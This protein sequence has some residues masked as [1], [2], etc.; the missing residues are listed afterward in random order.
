MYR[1]Y[2][3]L[4]LS[5]AICMKSSQRLVRQPKRISQRFS[6]LCIII[7]Y[8]LPFFLKLSVLIRCIHHF[9]PSSL[10]CR[11]KPLFMGQRIQ[12]LSTEFL[13]IDIYIKSCWVYVFDLYD[14]NLQFSIYR[15]QICTR[16]HGENA[17]LAVAIYRFLGVI[18]DDGDRW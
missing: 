10:L 7:F 8:P 16:E 17:V 3:C 18:D 5:S 12:R 14:I 13:H 2:S 6:K 9:Q 4:I 11:H 1:S 15:H